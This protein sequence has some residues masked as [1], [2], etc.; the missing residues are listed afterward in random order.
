MLECKGFEPKEKLTQIV[1][2][3]GELQSYLE[4]KYRIGKSRK[5]CECAKEFD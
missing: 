1:G 4:V 3:N 2:M 5:N